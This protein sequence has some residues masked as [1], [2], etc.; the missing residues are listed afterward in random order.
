MQRLALAR[1]QVVGRD[2][3]TLPQAAARLAGGFCSLAGPDHLYPALRAAL[4]QG[5]YQELEAVRELPG[6]ARA[7][8]R[9]LDLVWKADLSLESLAD[10]SPRIADLFLVEQRL[11]E[12][13]PAGKF[14]P[15][16]L[17]DAAL[18][19][20]H[21]APA[22]LG[23]ITLEGLLD[24]DPVWRPLV[25]AL[26]SD[27]DFVWHAPITSDRR[28]FP[29]RVAVT[30]AAAPKEVRAVVCADP[31]SEVVEALRWARELLSS[32][33]AAASDIGIVTPAPDFWDDHVL[34]MG[35]TSGLPLHFS[36]GVP[37]LSTREGQA[38]A[39]LADILV[40]GINQRR[41]RRLLR[42]IP[43]TAF[44][45][46]IPAD[47]SAGVSAKAGL[48]TVDHWR[49]AFARREAAAPGERAF[50][51]ALLDVLTLLAQGPAAAEEAGR[52]LLQG[53]SR[54]L[55]QEALRLA[56]AEAVHI[57]LG[58]LRVPDGRDSGN[59]IVWCPAS[60]LVASPRPWV[61]MI[62]LMSGSWPRAESEDPILPDHVLARR[63]LEPLSVCQR[64][65]IQ[66]E[67][68]KSTATAGLT[69]SRCRRNGTGSLQSPS[70]LWP[71]A[72]EEVLPKARI[73]V[74]A[75]SEPDRL[76]AR[77]EEAAT[78]PRVKN[79][80]A[81]W[82]EWNRPAFSLHDGTDGS[83]SVAVNRALATV[84]SATSLRRL[85]R[86]PLGFVWR[87]ALGWRAPQFEQQ[88]LTLSPSEFGELVHE[89]LGR[90]IQ[91]LEPVPGFARANEKQILEAL[92]AAVA[93]VAETWP[94]E[95]A[96]PPP[97]LWLH[98]LEEASQR[99]LR[100]LTVD[101]VLQSG[102]RSW[103]EVAFGETPPGSLATGPWNSTQAV[104]IPGTELCFGGRIDRLDLR[105]GAD[106]A[107]ISDYKSG[108]AAQNAPSLILDRGKE[109]QRVL[110]AMALR[111]LLPECRMIVSRLVYL[112]GETAP[113][114]LTGDTLEQ[115]MQEV[116]GFVLQARDHVRAQRSVAGDDV[117]EPYY[118]MGL[119]LPADRDSYLRRKQ[120][121]FAE[122][123]EHLAALWRHP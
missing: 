89:L 35:G 18:G 86:D 96:T 105:A 120:Q 103:T 8:A 56:P 52:L 116:A 6:T 71:S 55:W 110:Y 11:R 109:L 91:S 98:I 106:A 17:R 26:A 104:L 81:C 77:P 93:Q 51:P 123:N 30:P 31:R 121:V 38:C 16:Q 90:T 49:R 39:A 74:H 112:A 59:S 3:L 72:I 118:D 45:K 36:H 115:A 99:A 66:F 1:N 44:R 79:S 43:A 48:F 88:P 12:A 68:I 107:R 101:D 113:V 9:S 33:K 114:A 28:W 29:G 22:L 75:Y 111:Q 108:H 19:R 10:R 84:Q 24:I 100:G 122:A 21:Y 42:K 14:L 5:G 117:R 97:L 119:A 80:R 27:G 15:R 61:R 46:S 2:I 85:L 50:E 60:H 4:D 87:Y 40:N 94:L 23:A 37:A 25:A 64:D 82:A 58:S 76:L 67:V 34:V 102:T 47:W 83:V 13:L 69:L 95:R 53:Q 41:F 92:D 78:S 63:T 57:S 65:R 7:V 73:P 20:L 62:G 70:A 54:L 32:G